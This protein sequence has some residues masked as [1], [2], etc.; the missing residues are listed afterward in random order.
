MYLCI[1]GCSFWE[2]QWWKRLETL[3]LAAAQGN[4][5]LLAYDQPQPN[6]EALSVPVKIIMR[7]SRKGLFV[8]G[9][10]GSLLLIGLADASFW[11]AEWQQHLLDSSIWL[12]LLSLT[13]VA[14]A[15]IVFVLVTLWRQRRTI[16]LNQE[17]IRSRVKIWGMSE[18]G[19]PLMF[20][21]EARLFACYQSPVLWRNCSTLVYEL[22]SA[23]QVVTWTWV[24][25][26]KPL[27]I[28][29]VPTI[30]FEEHQAQMHALCALVAA[31]TG[32]L[33]YDLSARQG[34]PPAIRD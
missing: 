14:G 27:R 9:L 12:W 26:N 2:E 29:M 24:Q 8:F 11:I 15:A 31:K 6:P 3:R 25:E 23:S 28:G 5:R 33:L 20:W 16:E 18:M 1:I 21:H 17:G 32:L 34:V 30:P 7:L 10:L 19:S 4:D 22:S 13:V